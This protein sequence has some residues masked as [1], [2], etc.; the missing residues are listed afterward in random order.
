MLARCSTAA[1]YITL[2]KA[3]S[4]SSSS[5]L[6]EYL[7]YRIT[8]TGAPFV[9][10]VMLWG[11]GMGLTEDEDT[12]LADV[13]QPCYAALALANDYFSFD[14]EWEE[15]QNGGAQPTNA[16][17]LFMQ[18]HGMDVSTAKSMVREAV[19]RYELAFLERSDEFRRESPFASKKLDRYLR[20]LAYQV[21]G[22]VVWSLNCPRY[23][24]RL[25][26]NPNAGVK[27]A[28]T[29][30]ARGSDH[31][32]RRR[33]IISVASQPSDSSAAISESV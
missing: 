28:L 2:S 25:C 16:V 24:P 6:K 32:D 12:Q 5:S 11:M 18:W 4:N 33:S 23:H 15:A 22:N 30:E 3:L 10:S 21:S 7:A 19:N 1:L 14:R 29:A 20:G 26:Y 27:N 31:S 8:D 9:E 17:C 13:R